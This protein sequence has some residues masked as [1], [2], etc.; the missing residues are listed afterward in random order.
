MD[1]AAKR[2]VVIGLI[3]P[4]LDAGQGPQRRERWRPTVALC[5][6]EDLLV[7][8]FEL[9]YE[10]KFKRLMEQICEDIR[11]VSPETE[12]RPRLIELSNAWVDQ[13]SRKHGTAVRFNREAQE[14]FL[15]FADSPAAT[16]AGN[17]RDLNAAVTRMATLASGGRITVDVVDAEIARLK[18]S[19]AEQDGVGSAREC[20]DVLSQVLGDDRVTELDLF[21]R[22]QLA[23]VLRVCRESRTLSEAGRALFSSSRSRRLTRNDADR[24]RKYLARYRL[25]FRRV[26]AS[27]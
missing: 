26:Q 15:R 7:H 2:N 6:H 11:A 17:F 16:W 23:A 3:G 4:M 21:E 8:R 5:Q 27:D 14:T 20:D 10:L 18:Q 9:L 13:F 22:V 1:A 12:I 25:D 19:W 24:L